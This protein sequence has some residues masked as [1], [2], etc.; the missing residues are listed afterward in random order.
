MP[1]R[2]ASRWVPPIA[3][4]SPITRSTRPKQADSAAR[5]RSQAS[6]SSNAQVR[7]SAWAA[8]TVGHGSAVDPAGEL[9]QLVERPLRRLGT[10]QRREQ[11]DVDAA[12]DGAALGPEQ[13]P[14]GGL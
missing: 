9:D 2:S 1:A 5:I 10:V 4:V 13:H 3:G 14:A 7:H 11:R 8:K 6:A 12:G